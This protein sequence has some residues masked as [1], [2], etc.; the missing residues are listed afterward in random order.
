MTSTAPATKQDLEDLFERMSVTFLTKEDLKHELKNE[1]K[2]YATKKDVE[3]IVGESV[4]EVVS[5]VLEVVNDRFNS[6]DE[7]LDQMSGDIK[8]LQTITIRI[9]NKLN[10][11]VDI[12]DDHSAK[13]RLIQRKIA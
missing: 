2:A 10:D 7:R 12:A 9:D 5:Q 3:K 6:M 13:I 11:V 4:G 1:L 8:D